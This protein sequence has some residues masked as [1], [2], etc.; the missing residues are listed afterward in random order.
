VGRKRDIAQVDAVANEFGM[1][2]ETRGEYGDF[3]EE[4]KRLGRRGSGRRGD[5]SYGELRELAREYLDK[6]GDS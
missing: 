5:F 4:Q 6:G 1:D 3:L 2:R